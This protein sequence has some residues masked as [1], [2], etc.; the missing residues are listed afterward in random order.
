VCYTSGLV[1]EIIL[2]SL[3]SQST[4]RTNRPWPT[5]QSFQCTCLQNMKLSLQ[6]T[7]LFGQ[8]LRRLH[9]ERCAYFHSYLSL[10]LSNFNRLGFLPDV[11]RTPTP[12]TSSKGLSSIRSHSFLNNT[13]RPQLY[14]RTKNCNGKNSSPR[15]HRSLFSNPACPCQEK[16]FGP[17]R[18]SKNSL[19][20][21][22]DI[23]VRPL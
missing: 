14:K 9:V 10:P 3:S 20:S 1:L 17:T 22:A 19:R 15:P 21:I 8:N 23:V 2:D 11:S 4:R 13:P 7:Y 12:S 5:G 18:S 16:L 6:T